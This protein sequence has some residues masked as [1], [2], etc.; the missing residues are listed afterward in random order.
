MAQ[1]GSVFAQSMGILGMTENMHRFHQPFLNMN[2]NMQPRKI[3][4][5]PQYQQQNNAPFKPEYGNLSS[6][7]SP[8]NNSENNNF[9]AHLP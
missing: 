3:P 6:N 4:G 9:Y 1:M 5:Q 7:M 8:D 2:L